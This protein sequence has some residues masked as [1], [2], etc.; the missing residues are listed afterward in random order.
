MEQ[1]IKRK[2]VLSGVVDSDRMDKTIVIKVEIRRK[3]PLYGK[4]IR[5]SQRIKAH[6]AKNECRIGDTV[7]VVECRPLSREKCW[8]LDK[9]LERAK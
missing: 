3:H 1:N 2:K 5:S 9:I 4:I 8:R 6:D 7:R